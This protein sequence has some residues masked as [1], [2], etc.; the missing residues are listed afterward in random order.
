MKTNKIFKKALTAVA[1]AVAGAIS[2]SASAALVFQIQEG[3]VGA[4]TV[5]NIVTLDRVTGN[6]QER[7][8]FTGG[9]NFTAFGF[10]DSLGY[11]LNG[12]PQGSQLNCTFCADPNQGYALYAVFRSDGTFTP[13]GPTSTTFTGDPSKTQ[14]LE[15]FLDRNQDT[16]KSFVLNN[17]A[18]TILNTTDDDRVAFSFSLESGVGRQDTADTAAGNFELIFNNFT[19]DGALGNAFFPSPRPF[20][21]RIDLQGNFNDFSTAGPFADT[22]GSANASFIPEPTTLALLGASLLGLGFSTRRKKLS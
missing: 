5:S 12:V 4:P 2:T 9:N 19:L 7:V 13:T 17:A 11:T 14:S 16:T 21:D 18:P 15:I 3:A 6:Y 1:F 22:G 8:T 10:F 20:H